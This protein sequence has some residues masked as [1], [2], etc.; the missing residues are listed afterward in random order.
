MTTPSPVRSI[1]VVTAGLGVPSSTRLLGDRL[2]AATERHLRDASLEPVVPAVELRE[3]AQD[4]VH[5]VLTGFP[6]PSLQSAIDS[7]IEA[8]GLIAVSPIFHASFSGLFKL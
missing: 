5:R 6:S 3:H 4:L 1:V 2:A 7:V 8:D